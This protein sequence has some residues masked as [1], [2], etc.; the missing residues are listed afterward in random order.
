MIF[1]LYK[2]KGSLLHLFSSRLPFLIW[3]GRDNE[4]KNK[5]KNKGR[6]WIL[7]VMFLL[8]F[9]NGCTET[10]EQG[11]GESVETSTP[12][13]EDTSTQTEETQAQQVTGDYEED[14]L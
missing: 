5:M 10:K 13:S 9:G 14:D 6:V 4:M 11:S 12:N 7:F 2:E 3:A 1:S 8:C